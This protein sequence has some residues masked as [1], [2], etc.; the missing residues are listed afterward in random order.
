MQFIVWFVHVHGD[1]R[2]REMILHFLCCVRCQEKCYLLPP[3]D[4]HANFQFEY[5]DNAFDLIDSMTKCSNRSTIVRKN[6]NKKWKVFTAFTS[7]FYWINLSDGIALLAWHTWKW[8]IWIPTSEKLSRKKK[9]EQKQ[10][11]AILF[12]VWHSVMDT[13]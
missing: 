3:C 5:I 11:K 1:I 4:H 8:K 9:T 6:V 2:N 13:L 12:N 10:T 7:F